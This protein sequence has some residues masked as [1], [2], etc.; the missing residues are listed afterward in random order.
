MGGRCGDRECG[1]SH[2]EWG[3]RGDGGH[4]GG[5]GGAPSVWG[6]L[7]GW[8]GAGR[9]GGTLPGCEGRVNPPR[10]CR[11]HPLAGNWDE[12]GEQAGRAGRKV[13]TWGRGEGGGGGGGRAG[14]GASLLLGRAPA[15][16]TLAE[17]APA[18]RPL[19]GPSSSWAQTPTREPLNPTTRTTQIPQSMNP[20]HPNTP[21]N[22]NHQSPNPSN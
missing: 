11:P 9:D 7:R 14:A 21:T 17:G 12:L 22:S 20:N 2:Q 3:P 13:L 16:G 18:P 10:L 1:T 19:P 6:I 4:N 15:G 8:G 5:A